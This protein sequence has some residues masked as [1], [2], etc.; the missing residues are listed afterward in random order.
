[1]VAPP[2]TKLFVSK[3]RFLTQ[4]GERIGSLSVLA[5]SPKL[6]RVKKP[7][8]DGD[9]SMSKSTSLDQQGVSDDEKSN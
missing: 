5:F 9:C 8:Y 2:Y 1:M 3:V 4:Q 7:N 6:P